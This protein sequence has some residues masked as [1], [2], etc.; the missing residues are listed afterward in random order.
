MKNP[1]SQRSY[2][3]SLNSRGW[4][5]DST[6]KMSVLK[7]LGPEFDPSDTDVKDQHCGHT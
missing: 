6:S 5:N 3:L 1:S 2:F 7:A 4:E